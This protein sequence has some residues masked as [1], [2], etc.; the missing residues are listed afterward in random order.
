M[1]YF[2]IGVLIG[3]LVGNM[4]GIILTSIMASA[5]RDSRE[6]ELLSY[7]DKKDKQ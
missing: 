6:R 2:I 4:V 1:M 5:S 3:L 7:L